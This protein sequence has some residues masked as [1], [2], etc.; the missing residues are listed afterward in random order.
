MLTTG[1]KMKII[2]KKNTLPS[3]YNKKRATNLDA[4][5]IDDNDIW[6]IIVEI[7]RRDKFDIFLIL[8]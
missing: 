6:E 7:H 8:I 4:M 1:L 3:M 2:D 5:K